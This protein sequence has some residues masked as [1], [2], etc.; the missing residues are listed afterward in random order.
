MD[1]EPSR[2]EGA[3]TSA[4]AKGHA[5]PRSAIQIDRMSEITDEDIARARKAWKRRAP[6]P[7]RGLIDAKVDSEEAT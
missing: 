2:V 3:S 4:R 5:L 7:Y 6:G 1:N